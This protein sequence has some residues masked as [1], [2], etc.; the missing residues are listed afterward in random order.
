MDTRKSSVYQIIVNCPHCDIPV[1]IMSNEI[2]CA[3]FRHGIF[4]NNGRQMDPHTKKD[5]C[6]RYA[7]EGLI[8]GCGKPFRLNVCNHNIIA[9]V[10]DYI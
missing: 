5:L 1:Q 4:K 6:D 9:T 10:C 7:S 8:Y 2:N 3:I